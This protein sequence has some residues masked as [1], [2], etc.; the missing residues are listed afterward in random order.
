M[1]QTFSSELIDISVGGGKVNII[2]T[3]F[4]PTQHMSQTNFK[5]QTHLQNQF[6]VETD[7]PKIRT[8]TK[9]YQTVKSTNVG[10][11]H[12]SEN[13]VG[14]SK[15]PISFG[16]FAM[17]LGLAWVPYCSWVTVHPRFKAG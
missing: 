14:Q 17:C 1:C 7:L 6:H 3:V 2:G 15:L 8:H 10:D 12:V 5:N 16:A 11:T 4:H 13:K 9:N